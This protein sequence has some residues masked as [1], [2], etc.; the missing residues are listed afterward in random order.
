MIRE[1][2]TGSFDL[3]EKP[4]S[5]PVPQFV[6]IHEPG[7]RWRRG[8]APFEQEGLQA[9]VDH[10]RELLKSRKL[11]LGGPF[12]DDDGGGMMVA[13]AGVGAD[14]LAAFAA[15]DPTV[16]SGLLTFKVRPWLIGMRLAD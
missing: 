16:A 14:E 8:I 4:L 9:H 13:G 15:A 10:Y 2:N 11:M 3:L 1:S 6:V 5:K 12:L 7:P